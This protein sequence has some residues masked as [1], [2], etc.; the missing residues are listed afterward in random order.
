MKI[1]LSSYRHCDRR[2]S[3]INDRY[4]LNVDSCCN[5]ENMCHFIHAAVPRHVETVVK[6]DRI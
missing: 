5:S 4:M 3:V 6:L 1:S 2:H